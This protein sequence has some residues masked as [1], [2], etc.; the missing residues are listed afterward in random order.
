MRICGP[1]RGK[2]IGGWR[3]IN[4]EQLQ[5]MYSSSH[6]IRMI[7]SRKIRRTGN[8]A[9]MRENGNAYKILLGKPE[10]KRPLG[11]PRGM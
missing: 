1:K 2:I 3:K 10:V 11:R 9:R 7:K 5:Y 6:R 8:V 4:N